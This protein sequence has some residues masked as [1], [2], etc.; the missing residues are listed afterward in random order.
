[1]NLY[2]SQK[3]IGK[4]LTSKYGQKI[5][6]STNNKQHMHPNCFQNSNTRNTRATDDLFGNAIADRISKV[7]SKVVK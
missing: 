4:N 1:M 3:N 5:F 6:D 2:P 7:P